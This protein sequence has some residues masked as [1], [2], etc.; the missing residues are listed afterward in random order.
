MSTTLA[1]QSSHLC[2]PDKVDIHHSEASFGDISHVNV[3]CHCHRV[4]GG[5]YILVKSGINL[6]RTSLA[7]ALHHL[8]SLA[9]GYVELRLSST[10]LQDDDW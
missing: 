7:A 2:F 5:D 8:D 3:G 1:R 4:E 10:L 9:F 6:N